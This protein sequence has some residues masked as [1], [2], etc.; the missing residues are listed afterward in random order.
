M[1]SALYRLGRAAFRRRWFAIVGWL[2]AVALA[3][4]LAAGLSTSPSN[5]FSIPGVPSETAMNLME[6]RFADNESDSSATSATSPS[7][8]L[9]FHSTDGTLRDSTTQAGVQSTLRDLANG[10]FLTRTDT[11]ADPATAADALAKQMQD[12]FDAQMAEAEKVMPAPTTDEELQAQLQQRDDAQRDLAKNIEAVSPL[13]PDATTGTVAVTFDADTAQDVT[14]EQRSAFEQI[15]ANHRGNGLEIEYGGNAFQMSAPASG[16]SELIGVIFALVVL[17]V[18]F[19]ALVTAGMPI[20]TAVIGVAIGNL[21]VLALTGLTDTVN[22][23]TPML[24]SMLGLAVGI[25]YS[26]FIL[27]RYRSELR[28]LV[29]QRKGEPQD[30]YPRAKELAQLSRNDLAHAMGMAVG[31]AGSAVVFAGLTVIIALCALTIVGIPFLSTMALTAAGTVL[32]AV[33]VS[34]TFLPAIVSL[35]GTKVFAGRIPQLFIRRK[36]RTATADP[37]TPRTALEND[38]SRQSEK[39]TAPTD[40]INTQSTAPTPAM[41][42]DR[43][44]S[45]AAAR[46]AGHGGTLGAWWIRQVHRWPWEALL[47]CVAALVFLALPMS[48]MVLALP[49]D[50]TASPD[51]SPRKAYDL[52]DHA[53]GPGRNAPLLVVVDAQGT[54]YTDGT[55]PLPGQPP[56]VFLEAQHEIAQISGVKNAMITQVNQAG[57]TAMILVTPTT[58]S[59]DPSTGQTMTAIRDTDTTFHE[60]TGAHLSVTGVTAIST[61]ISDKLNSVVAPYVLIVLGLAF[62]VLMLVFRSILVPLVAAL[63]FGLTVTATFGLTVQI[64]QEGW[65]GI[66]SDPQPIISFLPIILIGIVFGLAMDYEVF[67]VSRIREHWQHTRRAAESTTVGFV[68]GVRVITAAALIMISVFAAFMLQDLLVIKMIGFALAVAVFLDAFIVRLTLI[69]ATMFILRRSAWWLPRWLDK[70]IPHIDV[71]GDTLATRQSPG[72]R[73][74]D[75]GS[76]D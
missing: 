16:L 7:A 69:P 29:A 14:A 52:L 11:L 30:D 51:S 4:G 66:I 67:L 74:M 48:K 24:A 41:K 2:A 44:N 57:D 62:L 33:L 12:A 1:A 46:Q 54:S 13:S 40:V 10:G 28:S 35:A 75:G 21:G 53:F 32:V 22:E 61:D 20:I 27:S 63:G 71:E 64:F 26:L 8:T 56:A 49:T 36:A 68:H 3:G 5:T 15:I 45:I 59:I 38:A 76:V 18:T 23:S 43:A 55:T 25:D 19:A 37:S 9:V 34:I 72:Q 31:T 17:A 58:G 47:V 70:L 65:A 73:I 6:E 39:K 50:A 42:D 60:K